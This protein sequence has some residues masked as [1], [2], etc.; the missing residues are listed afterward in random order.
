MRATNAST[1]P[2][3]VAPAATAIAAVEIQ[4]GHIAV[5]FSLGPRLGLTLKTSEAASVRHSE[6]ADLR[7]AVEQLATHGGVIGE[8]EGAVERVDGFVVTI[9]AF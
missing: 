4:A 6:A 1:P 9:H 8:P 3:E 7:E 5:P 2:A